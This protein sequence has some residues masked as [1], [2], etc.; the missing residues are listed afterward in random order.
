MLG[1]VGGMQGGCT[2]V[3]VP[4]WV[5]RVVY[6]E[7]YT[8]VL[9][10]DRAGRAHD[11]EAGPVRACRAL[12]WVVMGSDACPGGWTAPGYPPSGPGRL[13]L[14]GTQDPRECRLLANKGEINVNSL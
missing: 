5:Y 14:P 8:G 2:R 7:G 13:W 9:P 1:H 10:T 6:R 3:G 4:G 11:S 12:E